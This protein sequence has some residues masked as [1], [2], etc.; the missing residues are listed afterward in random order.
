[1]AV[2]ENVYLCVFCVVVN[3]GEGESAVLTWERTLLW[4][5]PKMNEVRVVVKTRVR[6]IVKHALHYHP[7]YMCASRV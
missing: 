3:K 2:G 6:V 4:R 5:E 1:M 7:P